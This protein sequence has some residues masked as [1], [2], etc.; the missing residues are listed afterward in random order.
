M[1]WAEAI[2]EIPDLQEFIDEKIE[3]GKT[4]L[5]TQTVEKSENRL[6]SGNQVASLVIIFFSFIVT[7]LKGQN[8]RSI[9]AQ[10]ITL[11]VNFESGISLNIGDL[12]DRF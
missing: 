9:L 1:S 10:Y 7:C 6:I 8:L 2:E 5:G 4:R 12:L 3:Y 11:I